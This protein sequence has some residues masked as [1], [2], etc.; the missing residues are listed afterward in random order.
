MVDKIIT[1]I[2]IIAIAALALSVIVHSEY[3]HIDAT[4]ESYLPEIQESGIDTVKYQDNT[5]AVANQSDLESSIE[6]GIGTIITVSDFKIN[7]DI[8]IPETCVFMINDSD[9]VIVTEDTALYFEG[10]LF[11]NYGRLY[12]DL[13]I[14]EERT[15]MNMGIHFGNLF[16]Y[17]TEV[18]D[19]ILKS[20]NGV[21]VIADEEFYYNNPESYWTDT[22]ELEQIILDGTPTIE[23]NNPPTNQTNH[24]GYYIPILPGLCCIALIFCSLCK[25]NV[26]DD[27]R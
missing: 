24:T 7:T 8:T 19:Y 17:D 20:T 13:Y 22:S 10:P 16:V 1:Y 18:G 27:T 4:L 5:F 14:K 15:F 9:V 6:K 3:E 26:K 25:D 12:G 11:I 21:P 2:C 23:D